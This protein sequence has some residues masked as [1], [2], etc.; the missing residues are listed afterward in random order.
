MDHHHLPEDVLI[1]ILLR[2]PVKSLVRLERVCKSWRA[3]IKSPRFIAIHLSHAKNNDRLLIKRTRTLYP[4]PKREEE[5]FFY[6]SIHSNIESDSS[7]SALS[8]PEK[9][10]TPERCI[11]VQRIGFGYDSNKDDYKVVTLIVIF[12]LGRRSKKLEIYSSRTDSWRQIDN[13]AFPDMVYSRSSVFFK[14]S[15]HWSAYDEAKR[16][17]TVFSLHMSDEVFRDIIEPP[18]DACA[19]GFPGIDV[20]GESL[21]LISWSIGPIEQVTFEIWVMEEYGVVESWT[22]KYCIGPGFG[23]PLACW[24]NELLFYSQCGCWLL[25]CSFPDKEIRK[26]DVC[27]QHRQFS[28][29]VYKE[30]LVSIKRSGAEFQQH[31]GWS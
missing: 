12:H 28:V 23:E 29:V 14:G 9:I 16:R 3:L 10:Y 22:K 26:F 19:Y 7:T 4:R 18:T 15:F 2:L 25:L 17:P 13:A 11:F 20:L 8:A 6:L 24:K 27:A 31:E 1:E 5:P 21:A 30:S